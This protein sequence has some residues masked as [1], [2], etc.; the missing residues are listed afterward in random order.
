M[1]DV[2]KSLNTLLVGQRK[3]TKKVDS[4]D[5]MIRAIVNSQSSMKQEL[6]ERI[7]KLDR[8]LGCRI[9][10]LEIKTEDGFIK[11]SERL[12]KIGKS[13]A[14]LEDDT[15]TIQEHNKLEK[16][17]GNIENKLQTLTT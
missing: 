14:Y 3:V 10:R 4:N 13:V 5:K 16:S 11:V 7:S 15:P 2:K 1:N 8:K 9:D 6:L 17:V 12:D